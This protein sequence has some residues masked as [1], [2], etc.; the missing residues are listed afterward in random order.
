LYES[1]GDVNRAIGA[2][3]EFA[4]TFSNDERVP[5]T[6]L[7]AGSAMRDSK[8]YAESNVILLD[9][10]NGYPTADETEVAELY[11]AFNYQRLGDYEN[12]IKYH[13]RVIDRGRRSLAVQSY[14]WLGV[15]ELDLGNRDAAAG[16]FNKV[17]TNYR[18]FPEWVRKAEAEIS[19]M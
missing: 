9:L 14:Y 18:D 4:E 16:Y 13:K 6:L 17:I 7:A 19:K 5:E 15:C 3:G 12:A 8:M 11:A 2:Y 1:A 10:I